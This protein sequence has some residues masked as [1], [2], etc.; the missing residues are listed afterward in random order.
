MEPRTGRDPSSTRCPT[1]CQAYVDR[2]V[3]AVAGPRPE[4]CPEG[5][6]PHR[7][8]DVNGAQD[9]LLRHGLPVP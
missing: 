7:A 9:W 8:G 3:S 5:L 6:P 2:P 1:G 4:S